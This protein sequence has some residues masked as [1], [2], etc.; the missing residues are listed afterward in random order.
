MS[1]VEVSR[2][3]VGMQSHGLGLCAELDAAVA[4]HVD[5]YSDEWADTLADPERVA[6]FT[7][8]VNAPETPDPSIVMVPERGQV[9]PA[10]ADEKPLVTGPVLEVVRA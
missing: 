1:R 3:H 7:S 9:R 4:G 6:L 8:L 2:A 10:R 5:T